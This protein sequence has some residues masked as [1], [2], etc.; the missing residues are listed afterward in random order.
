MELKEEDLL[1]EFGKDFYRQ[2]YLAKMNIPA[3]RTDMSAII[4]TYNRC[5]FG[6]RSEDYKYNP[7]SVCIKALLLQKSLIKEIVVVDDASTDNTR[8]VV[9]EL[10]REAYSTKGVEIKYIY[11]KERK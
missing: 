4:P 9:K 10:E 7:L 8:D 2:N 11:N 5:P 1:K 3:K 6:K